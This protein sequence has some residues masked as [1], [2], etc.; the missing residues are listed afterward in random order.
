MADQQTPEQLLDAPQVRQLFGGISEM[1]LFNW[2]RDDRLNFP[3]PI[4]IRRRRY[5]R[6]GDISAFQS[7][8]IAAE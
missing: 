1:T 4:V 3:K 5:W 7:R 6:A 8:S 2:Q